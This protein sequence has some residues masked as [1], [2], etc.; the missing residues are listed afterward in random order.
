MKSILKPFTLMML[1]SYIW[2][3][4][5]KNTHHIKALKYKKKFD[6]QRWQ[7]IVAE[8][9]KEILFFN[10][11]HMRA[12]FFL[13][14][15]HTCAYPLSLFITHVRLFFLSF[16]LFSPAITH[17]V[18]PSLHMPDPCHKPSSHAWP[19]PPNHLPRRQ[20][21]F[22][23]LTHTWPTSPSL[24]PRLGFWFVGC[25][26]MQGFWFGY[27]LVGLWFGFRWW[28]CDLRVVGGEFVIWFW[29]GMVC[30]GIVVVGYEF[31]GFFFFLWFWWLGD[32]VVDS[33]G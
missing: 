29:V 13:S 17:T 28:I 14:F 3:P 12:L 20:A 18:K 31:Y 33:D 22:P 23:R 5:H 19:M 26:F 11:S 6:T 8:C 27:N 1:K 21:I 32:E 9:Y 24:L 30:G 25:G 2:L 7:L 15:S 10:P 4:T 16:R